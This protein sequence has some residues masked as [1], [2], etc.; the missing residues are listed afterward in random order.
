MLAQPALVVRFKTHDDLVIAYSSRLAGGAI[1]LKSPRVLAVGSAVTVRIEITETGKALDLPAVVEH[2]STLEGQEGFVTAASFQSAEAKSQLEGFILGS[3]PSE[4]LA[5]S[6]PLRRK[7]VIALVDDS[8]MQRQIA[9]AP[10]LARGDEV[11]MAEDGLAGL[12]LCL[13]C[14]PDIILSDVQMPKADGWQLLRMLR[15][16]PALK[17]VPIIFL[18]TLSDEED[19]LRGYRLGVDDYLAKPYSPDVLVARVDRAVNRAKIGAHSIMPTANQALRGDLEQVS[20]PALLSFLEMER[21]SG[22]LHM[23][24][25]GS[26]IHLRDGCPVRA[27]TP[28][29]DSEEKG[30]ESLFNLL[31]RTKGRFEFLPGI[32]DGPDTIQMPLGLV[33]MEHAR[34]SDERTRKNNETA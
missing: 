33:L 26:A 29:I 2:C 3:D 17:R 22:I 20:L 32:V 12:A 14:E 6:E 21:K 10:F 19:R 5:Q 8:K 18:T 34:L 15:S 23:E 27:R 1:K 9:S 13:K 16:R 30:E 28:E 25:K 11:H 7:L 31:D 4:T 24:P